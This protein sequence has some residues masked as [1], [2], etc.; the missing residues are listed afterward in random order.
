L[1]VPGTMPHGVLFAEAQER[2]CFYAWSNE[3]TYS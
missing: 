1:R 3:L 2:I